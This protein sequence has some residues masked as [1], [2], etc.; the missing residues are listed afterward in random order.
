MNYR[1]IAQV[2]GRV[3]CI[4][5]ALMLLPL[6]TALYY[7]E[8]PVPFLVTI[9]LTAAAG[10]LLL[11]LRA[12]NGEMYA[13]EGFVCVGLS[14]ILMSLFGAL[15]FVIGRQIPNYVDALFETVSG[16]TTTGA[17]VLERVEKMSKSCLFWRSFTH[18]IGGMG[19]L[20]FLMAVLPM[21][22]EHS[23]H[24]MRAEIPGPTV[25]KLVPRA[26]QTSIIL[27]CIYFGLTVLEALFLVC[28]GMPFFDS[29]LNAFATAGTGGFAPISASIG[30]YHSAYAEWVITV[31]MLLFSLNFNLYF[32]ILMGK[33]KAALHSEELWCFGGIVA[34]SVATVAVSISKLYGGFFPA[35]RYSAFQVATVMS[36][37]GFA[38][39]DFDQWPAY[40]RC[41]L[42]LLMFIGACAG[43]TG[44]GIKLSRIMILFK[45]ASEETVRMIRPRQVSRVTMDGKRLDDKMVRCAA[46]FFVTYMAILFLGTV[47]VSLDGYDPT[48]NFTATLASLSNIGPGLSMVGPSGNYAM[49]SFRSKLVLSACMLL[50]RL[51][52]YPILMLVTPRVWKRR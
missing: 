15:P 1:M 9:L 32:L 2:L 22:G 34:F 5:A 47:V 39:A 19:V 24:I 4:E 6:L 13:R 38:T 27:Y 48:T 26:R 49:F 52:I 29:V 40:A 8:S 45:S 31:F 28:G 23:M 11:L 14:W 36:T 12:R 30:G 20:V 7:H 33:F 18:W 51:E 50:G 16:F 43:S 35:L 21:S 17:S 25:G 46:A 42:V 44:G 37:T 10:G 3:L 41:V